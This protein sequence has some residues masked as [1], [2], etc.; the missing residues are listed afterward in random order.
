[1]ALIG[2]VDAAYLTIEHYQGVIP[3]CSITKGCDK[4][5]T[6]TYASLFGIPTSLLGSIYYFVILAGVFAYIESKNFSILKWTLSITGVGFL[7]SLWF[8]YLQVFSIG[9]YCAYCLG[10]AATSTVLFILAIIVFKKYSNGQSI[11]NGQSFS[12]GQNIQNPNN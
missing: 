7:F 11:S 12:D 8:V 6:S 3:P 10:S 1:V 5:L 2:F 4:V 9:S